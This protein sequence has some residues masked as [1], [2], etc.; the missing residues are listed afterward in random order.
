MS[1]S[2]PLRVL[3]GPQ[4]PVSNLKDAFRRAALPEGPVAVISAGWQ[5]A[6]GY[7]DDVHELIG[8]P[9]LDLRLYGR[10]EK[11][12]QA[13]T[14]LRDA[15]RQRQDELIAQQ[16]LYKLRLRYALRAAR[17]LLRS[18]ADPATLAVEQRHA[19]SQIRTLDRH[20][21][22][23]VQSIQNRFEETYGADV[24]APIA[25]HREALKIALNGCQALVITGGNC[26][27][28]LNRLTLFGLA[29]LISEKPLFA[30][31]A[32]AMVLCNRIV[33]FHDRLPEGHRDAELLGPGLGLIP[34]YIVLPN[35]SLRIRENEPLRLSLFRRRFSTA[36]C[37]M[38]DSGSMLQFS[39]DRLVAAESVRRMKRTGGVGVLKAK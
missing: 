1:Q 19:I 37:A 34:N 2:E 26:I 35:A 8:Q 18:D 28:L 32:G 33:L 23:C 38:L 24:F 10:A 20:H 21:L 5:E 9:L 27:V 29:P 12:F 30:W 16:N 39:G 4:R 3:L 13:H 11:L 15:Y 14:A 17:E 22:Q 31:S 25:E 36:T 6:E 7:I